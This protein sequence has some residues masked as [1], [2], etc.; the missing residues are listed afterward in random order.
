M[1]KDD[2]SSHKFHGKVEAGDTQI[3][4]STRSAAR[5][6]LDDYKAFAKKLRDGDVLEEP[7]NWPAISEQIHMAADTIDAL[8]GMA[9]TPSSAEVATG[10]PSADDSA[11]AWYRCAY[12]YATPEALKE[13]LASLRSATRCKARN[14]KWGDWHCEC[15]VLSP[16]DCPNRSDSRSDK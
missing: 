15:G 12:P 7:L 5:R 9:S 13:G 10:Y 11:K 6:T 8:I 1:S 16:D 14:N 3:G 2:F 4:P